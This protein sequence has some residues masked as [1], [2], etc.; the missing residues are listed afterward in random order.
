MTLNDSITDSTLGAYYR[1]R[2]YATDG[3]APYTYEITDGS[4]P[5][6]VL[7]IES[8]GSITGTPSVADTFTFTIT[9]TDS[10]VDEEGNPDPQT[11]SQ[12]YTVLI[13]CPTLNMEG[14]PD[15]I[16]YKDY[17]ASTKTVNGTA[18]Y[19]YEVTSGTLPSGLSLNPS[20]G[21]VTGSPDTIETQTF[22]VKVTDA[23]DCE[24]EKSYTV[25]IVEDLTMKLEVDCG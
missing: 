15:G 24:G 5:D 17:S 7:L 13:E 16:Q 1:C 22:T 14:L 20:T 10:T 12:E 4:L 2:V 11:E 18:P 8:A 9:A 25:N 19:S 21:A 3:V 6:G 23:Y